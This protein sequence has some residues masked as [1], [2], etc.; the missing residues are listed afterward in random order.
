MAERS[1]EPS[2]EPR[3]RPVR[4]AE[5]AAT[6]TKRWPELAATLER[7]RG[8]RLLILLTGYPDPDNI[9]SAL[10]LQSLAHTYDIESS[11]LSFF[12]FSHQEN[13]AMVKQLEVDL[14]LYDEN[15]NLEPYSLY[16][17]VDTQRLETPIDEE[18][19]QKTFLA[20]VDHHKKTGEVRA[21]F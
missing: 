12:E 20:F 3:L 15:F 14:H 11:L 19:S 9:G 13:R 16:A 10:A 4:R 7:H 17:F 5:P 6:P 1:L 8:E 18:L 2:S 21:E